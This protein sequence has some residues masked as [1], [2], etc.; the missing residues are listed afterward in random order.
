[1]TQTSSIVRH[2]P[3]NSDLLIPF[4]PLVGREQELA[5]ICELLR[6]PE[7]RLLTLVGTGGVGKTRLGL[8]VAQ[9]VESEFRDGVCF[10]AL[11]AAQ[12][13]SSV[14]PAIAQS[15]GL[16]ESGEI[17]V[18]ERVSAALRHQ[19]LL[20]LL[21]N[22][23]HVIEAAPS[24]VTLLASCPHLRI[25]VTSRATLR[26]S[27]E[28]QFAVSPLAMPDLLRLPDLPQLAQLPAVRLFVLRAQ[29]ILSTFQLTVANAPTIAAICVR[30]DG[31][32]LA[33]ELAAARI[34]LLPPLALLK[35]LSHRLQVL[36]EGARDLPPRQQTLRKTIQWSYE[37][38]CPEEQLLFRWL[39]IFV[40]GCTLEAAEA[41]CRAANLPIP[42][43]LEGVASLLN[44]S[45]I[46]Q[47]ER[48]G[49][50][51]RLLI[52]ETLRE[53]GLEQL[54]AH[55]EFEE[56]SRVHAEYFT[57]MAE[58]A[59]PHFLGREPN[60]WLG[61]WEQDLDNVRAVLRWAAPCGEGQVQ[62]A[63][64]LSSALREFWFA[65][66]HLNEGCSF[67]KDFLARSEVVDAT[68]RL[69]ALEAATRLAWFQPNTQLVRP[70]A[71]HYLS[72]AQQ[73]NSPLPD[74]EYLFVRGALAL[75]SPEDT[76]ARVFLEEALAAARESNAPFLGFLLLL[77]GRLAL[78][79]KELRKAEQLLEESVHLN[80]PLGHPAYTS[81]LYYFA[82][83]LYK[84]GE[85]VRARALL[86]EDLAL[87]RA[88]DHRWFIAKLLSALGQVAL[89]QGA[90]EIAQRLC[91]EGIELYRAM[92]EQQRLIRVLLV[93]AEIAITQQ[94][95]PTAH[96]H[97]KESLTLA[98][99]LKHNRFSSASL[100]G[101][102]VVAAATGQMIASAHLWGV[103]QSLYQNLDLSIS[104]PL[105]EGVVT[106]VCSNLGEPAFMHYLEEGR[107][108]TP[109]QVLASYE[110]DP[111]PPPQAPETTP[112]PETGPAREARLTIREREVLRLVAQ[113]LSD[114]QI[115]TQLIISPRTVTTHL[116]S[117]YAKLGVNS[118]ATAAHLATGKQM[119]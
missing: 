67:L 37:L 81:S 43:V 17:R 14:L 63:L 41:V 97:Y 12:D 9:A 79:R 22:F 55:G 64:R 6:R 77:L 93:A 90:L 35:R 25:L 105:F 49:D 51:P 117:I 66:G 71:Q 38:L 18:E 61:R 98:L 62:L 82:R 4:A 8:A 26:L 111:S 28:Y 87:C 52:L 86:E 119:I 106:R 32:P 112:V 73:T 102:G 68:V 1:M 24:L 78:L 27:D 10:V 69:K 110:K 72:L 36:T 118:R 53:F 74:T 95:Y 115:A 39:S 29:S 76:P 57:R 107:A 108:M 96:A 94:A 44:K 23:E 84:Q 2:D 109:V 85:W 103:A 113:G 15:L 42:S 91:E 13:A 16:W 58:E 21:D 114:A 89:R 34:K 75:S 59:Q 19:H 60:R 46:Q 50:E 11:A 45:L 40:G 56:A 7:V 92:G 104:P 99:E 5:T 20:L 100:Q 47:M 54:A 65:C 116:S 88:I 80:R 30:V 101:L 48:E 33:L 70:L 31:L 83:T 3:L